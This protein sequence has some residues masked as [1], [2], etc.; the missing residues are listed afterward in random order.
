LTE[1]IKNGLL[2][3][4]KN[5]K[6]CEMIIRE[7]NLLDPRNRG[8][9]EEIKQR[10]IEIFKSVRNPVVF[11]RS[12]STED[13]VSFKQKSGV[14]EYRLIASWNEC[15]GVKCDLKKIERSKK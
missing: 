5:T 15:L 13:Y 3:I 7:F 11:Q 2:K 6:G 14:V 12:T 4:T 10:F 8:K 1:T 9:E